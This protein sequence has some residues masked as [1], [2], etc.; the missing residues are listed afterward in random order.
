MNTISTTGSLYI[1]SLTSDDIEAVK[2]SFGR[3]LIKGDLIGRFY[4]IFLKSHPSI[5]PMFEKTDLAKQKQLLTQGINLIVLYAEGKS[6][7][8]SGLSRIRESHSKGKMNISP[9]YYNFW[10]ESLIT[11]ITEFDPQMSSSLLNSWNKVIVK[12]IKF[13][14]EGY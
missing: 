13:I 1:N 7:G 10:K 12:G 5:G 6:V 2:N 14:T 11:A 4:E 9:T 8:L 3:A